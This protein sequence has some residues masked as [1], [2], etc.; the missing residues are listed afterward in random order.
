M[1][2][3]IHCLGCGGGL[4]NKRPYER[5]VLYSFDGQKVQESWKL[6][7][8]SVGC[9]VTVDLDRMVGTEKDPG[10]MCRSCFDKYKTFS[11]LRNE[12]QEKAEKALAM[13]TPATT[14]KRAGTSLQQPASKRLFVQEKQTSPAVVVSVTFSL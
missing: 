11:K 2:G 5:R 4:G 6:L 3:C 8:A 12:L 7:L 9:P 1:A 13:M 10:Y 14:R